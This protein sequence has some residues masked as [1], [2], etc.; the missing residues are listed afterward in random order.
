MKVLLLD[1]VDTIK[2]LTY[3]SNAFQVSKVYK[4]ANGRNK[5]TELKQKEEGEELKVFQTF[6][7]K[8]SILILSKLFRLSKKSGPEMLRFGCI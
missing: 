7:P 3:N 5:R 6:C 2:Y 8:Y 1:G 4:E